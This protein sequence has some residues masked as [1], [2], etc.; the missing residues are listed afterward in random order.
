MKTYLV[1]ILLTL[2]NFKNFSQ[3]AS[4]DANIKKLNNN[5]FII[6]HGDKPMFEMKS[7][8]A[9]KLKKAGKRAVPKLILALE[10]STKVIMAH[11]TLCHI[12]FNVAT[13]AGP[14]EKTINDTTIYYYFFLYNSTEP[15]KLLPSLK[16]SQ[17]NLSKNVKPFTNDTCSLLPNSVFFPA[18]PRFIGLTCGWCMFTILFS[19]LRVCVRCIVSCCS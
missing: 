13:F 5:Q 9:L 17:L 8:A 6:I 19:M 1:I 16:L 4:V 18:F 15:C 14:K 7:S 12:Y 10:D 3:L 2:F 11:L